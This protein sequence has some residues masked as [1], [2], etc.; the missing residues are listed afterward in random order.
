MWSRRSFK[1]MLQV[2]K[3]CKSCNTQLYQQS[4]KASKQYWKNLCWPAAKNSYFKRDAKCVTAI[5]GTFGGT[6]IHSHTLRWTFCIDTFCRITLGT[7][8]A[9]GACS[10]A[11][12]ATIWPTYARLQAPYASERKGRWS[13]C[14][15]QCSAPL[16]AAA[17][18]TRGIFRVSAL[19]HSRP[20]HKKMH[21]ANRS[22]LKTP[23]QKQV[24][25][26]EC[27]QNISY[28]L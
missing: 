10:F 15:I 12:F 14:S 3:G 24:G 27:V 7:T 26:R 2:Y 20:A 19:H 1:C 25:K 22:E 4:L 23:E 9:F 5:G 16:V 11:R 18:C 28:E 8:F 13:A 21:K 17:S 6:H